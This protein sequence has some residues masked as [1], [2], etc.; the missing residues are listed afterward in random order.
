MERCLGWN[1]NGE[2]N[3][4]SVKYEAEVRFDCP[5]NGRSQS[6]DTLVK[7]LQQLHD[8]HLTR[9]DFDENS[10]EEKEIESVTKDITTV[11]HRSIP[12]L[13]V[14]RVNRADAKRVSHV[15]SA[16]VVSSGKAP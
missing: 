3:C 14:V 2:F 10:S 5:T 1:L 7:K 4:N 12:L 16:S 9:P 13:S 15:R 8:K 6:M 11:M